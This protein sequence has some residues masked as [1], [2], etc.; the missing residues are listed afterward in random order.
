[1]PLAVV[2]IEINSHA[3]V[4]HRWNAP[5]KALSPDS[6]SKTKFQQR[7]VEM[8]TFLQKEPPREN[9]RVTEYAVIPLDELPEK[10]PSD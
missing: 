6:E 10:Y 5:N 2:S 3:I 1:M 9:G 7:E 4:L 8:E